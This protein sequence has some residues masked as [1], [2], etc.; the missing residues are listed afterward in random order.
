MTNLIKGLG[1]NGKSLFIRGLLNSAFTPELVSINKALG[2]LAEQNNTF[3]NKRLNYSF[4]YNSGVYPDAEEPA[5]PLA[6]HLCDEARL[7]VGQYTDTM[8]AKR[9][10]TFF[11]K[12]L[13]SLCDTLEDVNFLMPDTLKNLLL[14]DYTNIQIGASKLTQEFKDDFIK[15]T[16]R[17]I[18]P[19][20]MYA[21]EYMLKT[22]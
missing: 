10:S 20:K 8:T 6:E 3:N 4:I 1:K 12:K 5:I 14:N 11:L 7:I 16:D 18:E 9:Y 2:R 21:L 15:S 22:D 19:I 13:L 17:Y